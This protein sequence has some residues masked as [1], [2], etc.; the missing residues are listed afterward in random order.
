MDDISEEEFNRSVKTAF[1]S[2]FKNV[3]PYGKPFQPKIHSR[4]LLY[5]YRWSL[6]KPWLDPVIKAI[7]VMGEQGFYV[8]VFSRL[9]I[10][11]LPKNYGHWYVPINEVNQYGS[12]VFSQESAIYS[13]SGQW[14]IVCSDYD[15]ALLGGTQLLVDEIQKS[16]PDLEYR[17]KEF[18]EVCK[19]YNKN[20]GVDL[21]WLLPQL[22]HIYGFEKARSLINE[23]NLGWLLK[24][25]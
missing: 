4:L 19:E 1:D 5:N 3:N 18:L 11:D 17:V 7:E 2:V 13:V 16:V 25:N 14:G 9:E 23:V 10:E 20:R 22:E 6:D 21:D 12:K 24:N 8:T 15:H